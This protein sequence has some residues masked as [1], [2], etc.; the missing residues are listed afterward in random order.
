MVQTIQTLSS[1]V[2]LPNFR[3]RKIGLVHHCN[4]NTMTVSAAKRDDDYGSGSRTGKLVDENMVV[5][6]MRIQEMK[7]VERNE[8]APEHWMEWEKRYYTNYYYSDVCEAVGL[9]QTQLMKTRPTVAL[10][11]VALFMVSV[12]MSTFMVAFHLMKMANWI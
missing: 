1:P 9:L 8:E 11:M 6:R 3:C 4:R 10:G 2:L 5:L 12:P 7:M